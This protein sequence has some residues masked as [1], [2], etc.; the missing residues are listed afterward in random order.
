MANLNKNSH[1]SFIFSQKKTLQKSNE[2]SDQVVK[3]SNV[4]VELNYGNLHNFKV[5]QIEIKVPVT[6]TVKLLGSNGRYLNEYLQ[7][8][9]NQMKLLS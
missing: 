7:I 1:C 4:H 9:I 2:T 8:S 5:K 6:E 3:K